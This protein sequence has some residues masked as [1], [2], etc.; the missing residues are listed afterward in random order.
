MNVESLS[1]LGG[2]SMPVK[3]RKPFSQPV[4]RLSIPCQIRTPDTNG[5]T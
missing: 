1:Q 2:F 5:I 4:S 3:R